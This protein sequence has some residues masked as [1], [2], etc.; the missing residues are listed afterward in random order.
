VCHNHGT[1]RG[2]VDE[3]I[4]HQA[5]DARDTTTEAASGAVASAEHGLD[6][7]DPGASVATLDSYTPAT[8]FLNRIKKNRA[9][10]SIAQEIGCQFGDGENNGFAIDRPEAD[11]SRQ[12]SSLPSHSLDIDRPINRNA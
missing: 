5:T 4:V 12:D 8:G 1:G 3:E 10:L 11:R 7:R 2:A 9:G 6:V